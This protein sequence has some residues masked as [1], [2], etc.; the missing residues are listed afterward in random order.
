MRRRRPTR[1]RPRERCGRLAPWAHARRSNVLNGTLPARL[2]PWLAGLPSLSL[3]WNTIDAGSAPWPAALCPSLCGAQ[4]SPVAADAQCVSQC[5]STPWDYAVL[6]ST[7]ASLNATCAA[8]AA[9]VGVPCSL[10]PCMPDFPGWSAAAATSPAL[11]ASCMNASLSTCVDPCYQ[12]ISA[13]LPAGAAAT[14][15]SSA[16]WQLEAR[17]LAPPCP[18]RKRLV[19]PRVRSVRPQLYLAPFPGVTGDVLVYALECLSA[20]GWALESTGGACPVDLANEQAR[21]SWVVA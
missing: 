3:A 14:P 17:A 8:W 4:P 18:T 2:V 21:S 10:P 7:T 15:V 13:T 20:P 19:F 1:L 5:P 16:L 6:C 9:S 11:V 12:G